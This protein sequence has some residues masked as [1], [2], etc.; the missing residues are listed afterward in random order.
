V[1]RNVKSIFITVPHRDLPD[2]TPPFGALAVINS[3]RKAGY[4]DTILYNIDVLRHSR[5][6]D[7]DY[8]V[9]YNPEILCISA[10]VS[11]GYEYCKFISLELKQRLPNMTIILGGNLAVSAEIL[12][13]KTGVDFCVLGEGERVCC[14]LFDKI[15]ENRPRKD[16]YAIKGLAFLDGAKVIINGYA[17]QLSGEEIFDIDWDILDSASVKCYFPLC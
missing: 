13:Q 9:N 6:D 16:L 2:I 17:D 10:P 12:L 15:A 8:I 3:L 14:Q 5:E 7:I 4:K 1:T 11:T